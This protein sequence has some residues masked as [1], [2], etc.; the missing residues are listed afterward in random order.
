MGFK[1]APRTVISLTTASRTC[2]PHWI[3]SSTGCPSPNLDPTGLV[4][5]VASF[6]STGNA[7]ASK[8]RATSRSEAYRLRFQ[9]LVE[10]LQVVAVPITLL[11]IR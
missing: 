10:S 2:G 1:P 8:G 7:L 11:P 5:T 3:M 9:D 6:R 4:S